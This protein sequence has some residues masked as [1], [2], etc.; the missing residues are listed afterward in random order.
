MRSWIPINGLLLLT[1]IAAAASFAAVVDR[2]A[3]IVGKTAFTQSEV[4]E[5]ARLNELETGSPLDVSAAKR[6]EAA[7]RMV[8]QQL[9]RDEIAATEFQAPSVQSEA[10]L[11]QFCKDRF[12]QMASCHAAFERYGVTETA[13]RQ[14]LAWEVIALRFTDE[15][16]RPLPPAVDGQNSSVDGNTA[17][18]QMDAWLKQRRADTRVVFKEEAFQ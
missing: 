2:L 9:L 8:D 4:E 6:R 1:S 5:E 14:R 10:L 17:D 11:A 18:Q 3:L 12:A 16:F 15:R 7:E 13:V